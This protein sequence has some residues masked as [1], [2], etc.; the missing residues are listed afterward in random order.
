MYCR[1]TFIVLLFCYC[2]YCDLFGYLFIISLFTSR[3][4]LKLPTGVVDGGEHAMVREEGY[5]GIRL[6]VKKEFKSQQ[7][8]ESARTRELVDEEARIKEDKK[9][10]ALLNSLPRSKLMAM[11]GMPPNQVNTNDNSDL[12]LVPVREIREH[13]M[14]NV[15]NAA[16][17]FPEIRMGG[18]SNDSDSSIHTSD[19]EDFSDDDDD[20]EE[21]L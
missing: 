15:E 7:V 17:G 2:F 16:E 13:N 6:Q 5:F 1:N 4:L 14:M 19:G 9:A 3:F 20:E 18:D 10:Q 21:V 12:L 11:L 8:V